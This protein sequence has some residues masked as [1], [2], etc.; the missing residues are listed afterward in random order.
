M[1][2]SS[3]LNP[4]RLDDQPRPARGMFDIAISSVNPVREAGNKQTPTDESSHVSLMT[5]AI[6]DPSLMVVLN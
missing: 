1:I 6:L 4:G 3:Y 5:D 2:A